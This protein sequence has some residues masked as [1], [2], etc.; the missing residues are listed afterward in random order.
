M[1]WLDIR[2]ATAAGC[3]ARRS[4][5]AYQS[6]KRAMTDLDHHPMHASDEGAA[7]R[8]SGVTRRGADPV[9]VDAPEVIE[10]EVERLGVKPSAG[11]AMMGRVW[12]A[13]GPVVA[14]LFID[15]G[16]AATT[17]I[18]AP[19]GLPLGMLA[20]YVLAGFLGVS[21]TWR[22][23]ITMLTGLY[24]AVPFTGFLPFATVTAAV[25][26]VVAPNTLKEEPFGRKP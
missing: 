21:P 23:A 8:G 20:G 11:R 9:D 19:L 7:G 17:G 18:F 12:N 3:K 4:L 10:V 25:V 22:I 24:W 16:D 2:M 15:A 13:V 1:S 14:A 6:P 26:Q 5:P